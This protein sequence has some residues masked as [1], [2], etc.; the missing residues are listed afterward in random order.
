MSYRLGFRYAC[1]D[2]RNL[3]IGFFDVGYSIPHMDKNVKIFRYLS[4]Y[5]RLQYHYNMLK[6]NKLIYFYLII[7][8]PKSRD[9]QNSFSAAGA[10]I[11]LKNFQVRYEEKAKINSA[12]N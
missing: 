12:Q 3:P 6:L 9:N 11:F 7:L 1:I 5:G 10:K 4:I 8:C 2:T